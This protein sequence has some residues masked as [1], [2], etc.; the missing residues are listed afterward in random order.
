MSINNVFKSN[1]PLDVE[2]VINIPHGKPSVKIINEIAALKVKHNAIS[3]AIAGNEARLE[4]EEL[5]TMDDSAIKKIQRSIEADR[6]DLQILI[7]KAGLLRKI[8]SVSI[9][10]DIVVH[11]NNLKTANMEILKKRGLK[12]AELARCQELLMQLDAEVTGL[13]SAGHGN[14]IR[15]LERYLT[16]SSII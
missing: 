4:S 2:L 16:V 6:Q 3:G 5:L 14:E 9:G 11:I 12:S 10:E 13:N 1:D 7:T 15:E 8:L